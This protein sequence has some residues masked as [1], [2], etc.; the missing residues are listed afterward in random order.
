MSVVG[1]R[2][3]L[4]YIEAVHAHKLLRLSDLVHA[5]VV[6]AFGRGKIVS[7]LGAKQNQ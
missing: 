6:V 7:D 4:L 1:R 5:V 2:Q 3:S